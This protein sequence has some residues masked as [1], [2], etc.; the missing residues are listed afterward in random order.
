M[1]LSCLPW[2]NKGEIE[3]AGIYLLAGHDP[4]LVGRV[5]KLIRAR[6]L[7][8]GLEEL[9]LVRMEAGRDTPA[10]AVIEAGSE[11]PMLSNQR[12]LQLRGL[13]TM[14]PQSQERLA[15]ELS[16]WPSTTILAA[17]VPLRGDDEAL[18]GLA[19]P[20]K[21]IYRQRRP[22]EPLLIP[23][24]ES[25][26][27]A[28]GKCIRCA[29]KDSEIRQW[30]KERF[31]EL[32]VE[33]D[34]KVAGR[35]VELVGNDAEALEHE[36]M[37]LASYVGTRGKVTTAVVDRLTCPA[38][39]TRLAVLVKAL[40]DGDAG[41]AL[42]IWKDMDLHGSVHPLQAISYLNTVFARKLMEGKSRP[43]SDPRKVLGLLLL[44]DRR[45]K[46]GYP[47]HLIM[48]LLILEICRRKR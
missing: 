31:T 25:A 42:V 45:L 22:G 32:K 39:E 20:L 43:A 11:L 23:A 36:A 34:P 2:L 33:S 9:N 37:K 35:M 7:D 30:L 1:L 27:K 13:E 17:V 41:R 5:M 19:A 48:E 46:S 21:T 18:K 40:D 10:S 29:L 38:P 6:Y 12:I 26:F 8:P 16:E 44:A 3:P 28:R 24:L 15:G 47:E 4:C 14:L